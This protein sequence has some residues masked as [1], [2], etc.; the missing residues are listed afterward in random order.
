[1]QHLV[2][3]DNYP[4]DEIRDAQ[5]EPPTPPEPGEYTFEDFVIDVQIAEGQTGKWIDGIPR[6]KNFK[7]NTYS[8]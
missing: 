5:P 6:R 8:I 1:M 2:L 7:L 4:L 3:G